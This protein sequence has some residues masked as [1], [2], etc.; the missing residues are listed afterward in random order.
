MLDKRLKK[1]GKNKGKGPPANT[2]ERK[3]IRKMSATGLLENPY[4]F[5]R[6]NTLLVTKRNDERQM[7]A[8]NENHDDV[9][10]SF[11]LQSVLALPE[12][13]ITIKDDSNDLHGLLGQDVFP[14]VER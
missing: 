7:N 2:R 5:H 12:N 9:S 8:G 4:R 1:I 10:S 6:K 13:E 3:E 14:L 11:L